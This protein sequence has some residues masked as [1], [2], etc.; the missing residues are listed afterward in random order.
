MTVYLSADWLQG[1]PGLGRNAAQIPTVVVTVEI[2]RE[3]ETSNRRV[4]ALKHFSCPQKR[5]SDK[6]PAIKVQMRRS[7]AARPSFVIINRTRGQASAVEMEVTNIS[8]ESTLITHT[9]KE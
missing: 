1:L 2:E 3:R 6:S 8:N 7:Q 4:S 5:G 9:F